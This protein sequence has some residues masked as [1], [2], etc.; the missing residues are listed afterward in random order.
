MQT[1]QLDPIITEVRAIRDEYTERFDNDVGK[2]F[3]DL[4]ARQDASACGYVR[5]S[6]PAARQSTRTIPS[7]TVRERGVARDPESPSAGCHRTRCG[8]LPRK[9]SPV[10]ALEGRMT[11]PDDLFES[12][13]EE[14]LR[15]WEGG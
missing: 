8:P 3:R 14:E 15:L 13:S 6:P 7:I 2:M 11:V 9:R 5:H 12:I 4:R 1:T 10:G